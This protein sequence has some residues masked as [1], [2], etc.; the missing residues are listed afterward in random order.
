MTTRQAEQSYQ[1]I[2]HVKKDIFITVGKLGRF[3]F[4]AGFYIYTGSAKRGVQSRVARHLA[5]EKKLHWHIDYLLAHKDAQIAKTRVSL[6]PECMLNQGTSGDNFPKGFGASD[7][8]AHCGGHLKYVGREQP[9]YS[10]IDVDFNKT[11]C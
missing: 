10:A 6:E 8:R 7:C 9:C 4:L 11:I 3:K 1:L 2:V 5:A